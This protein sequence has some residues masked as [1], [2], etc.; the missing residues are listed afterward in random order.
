MQAARQGATEPRLRQSHTHT[1]TY[2]QKLY[3]F[4]LYVCMYLLNIEIEI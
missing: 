2:A 3:L 1:R 4:K